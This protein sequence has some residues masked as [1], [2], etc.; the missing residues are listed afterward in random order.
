MYIYSSNGTL[1]NITNPTPPAGGNGGGGPPSSLLVPATIGH[2]SYISCYTEGT[3]GRALSG[4][5]LADNS[6][7]LQTCASN[8]T[9]FKYFGVEYGRGEIDPP[10]LGL[11]FADLIRMLLRTVPG[12]WERSSN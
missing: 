5:A 2:F 8:C 10:D 11:F 3:N 7:T 12:C 6:I 1:P 9:S 4:F